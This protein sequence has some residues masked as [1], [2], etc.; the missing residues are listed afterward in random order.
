MKAQMQKGV[1]GGMNKG[2]GIFAAFQYVLVM[3]A[4]FHLDLVAT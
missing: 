2:V 1:T 3:I 4:G